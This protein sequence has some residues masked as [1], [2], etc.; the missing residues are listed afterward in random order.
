MSDNRKRHLLSLFV[1]LV[2]G[3]M[4][5]GSY[6][7]KEETKKDQS[8]APSYI[9]TADQLFGDYESSEAAADSKYKGRVVVVSGTIQSTGIDLMNNAYIVIGGEGLLDG[10]QCSFIKD[11]KSSV[12]LLSRGQQVKVKGEVVGRVGNVLI[13]KCTLQ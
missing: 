1:L 12:A 9:L 6:D 2:F 7:T 13:Y 8:Q 3:L 5:T 11:Q 10:V 4:A